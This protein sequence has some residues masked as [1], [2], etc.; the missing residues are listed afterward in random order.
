MLSLTLV[1]GNWWIP[2]KSGIEECYTEMIDFKNKLNSALNYKIINIRSMLIK[3]DF[4]GD[5]G[6]FIDIFIYFL[7]I[8][9]IILMESSSVKGNNWF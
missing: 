2:K 5:N 4:W 8:D 9:L 3:T 6:K 7:I 1:V